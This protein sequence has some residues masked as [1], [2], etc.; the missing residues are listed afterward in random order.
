MTNERAIDI[1]QEIAS[2][3]E[4]ARVFLCEDIIDVDVDSWAEKDIHELMTSF[5][6][7]IDQGAERSILKMETASED[8]VSRSSAVEYARGLKERML[9]TFSSM[10]VY[11]SAHAKIKEEI[12]DNDQR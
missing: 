6:D 4:T 2:K 12:A 8:R 5:I 9:D 3:D 7:Y 10:A 1:V 11:A